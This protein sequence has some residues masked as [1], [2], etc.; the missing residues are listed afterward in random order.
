MII[1]ENFGQNKFTNIIIKLVAMLICLIIVGVCW[2]IMT[3]VAYIEKSRVNYVK[4]DCD[5]KL[6]QFDKQR[7]YDDIILP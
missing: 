6:I 2:Y 4:S 3:W 5:P 1:W 7:A